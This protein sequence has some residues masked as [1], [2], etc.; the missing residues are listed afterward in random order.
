MDPVTEHEL[1]GHE[2]RLR[3]ILNRRLQPSHG[4]Q[5]QLEPIPWLSPTIHIGLQRNACTVDVA[6]DRAR[7]GICGVLA[8]RGARRMLCSYIEGW[9]PSRKRFAF[10]KA[11][12]TFFLEFRQGELIAAKQMFRLEWDNW[13]S[14]PALPGNAAY[15]HWQFDRW[16]TASDAE[17]LARLRARFAAPE[18]EAIVFEGA[19]QQI[20]AAD[21]QEPERPDL[22]WFTRLHFPAIAP[23][24]TDPISAD[25]REPVSHRS[26]PQSLKQLEGW[27][28]S[29]LRYVS[30]EIEAYA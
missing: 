12:M 9:K 25:A 18:P 17:Q 14:N 13:Q 7:P 10:D 28:D 2:Q 4:A 6:G 22:A 21:P 27:T 3:Q 19:E 29:A 20:Q 23:W 16:L 11:A 8:D 26:V 15:P 5:Y 30:S 1:R 24:A